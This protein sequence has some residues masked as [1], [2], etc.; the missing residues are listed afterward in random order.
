MTELSHF[1]TTNE[2]AKLFKCHPDTVDRLQRGEF[3]AALGEI[4]QG[5]ARLLRRAAGRSDASANRPPA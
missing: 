5:I 2:I 3:D 4:N 1:L